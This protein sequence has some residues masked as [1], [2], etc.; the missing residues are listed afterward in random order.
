VQSLVARSGVWVT[1]TARASARA[2]GMDEADI[3]ECLLS[4]QPAEFRKSDPSTDK[5]GTVLD[6]YRPRFRGLP[7]YVKIRIGATRAGQ[8]VIVVSFRII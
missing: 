3:I 6:V 1:G 7:L 2:L 4:L 5:P 8:T